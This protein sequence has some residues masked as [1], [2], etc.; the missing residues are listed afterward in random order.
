MKKIIVPFDFSITSENALKAAALLSKKY[1]AELYVLHMLEMSN[2]VLTESGNEQQAKSLFYLKLAEQKLETFLEKDYLKDVDVTPIV[3]HFKVFSELNDVSNEL[4]ADLIVMGSKGSSGMKE[5]FI[6]SNTEKVV[7]YSD[8]PVLIIKNEPQEMDFENVVFAS[9]FFEESIHSYL[10]ACELFKSLDSKVHLLYVNLPF[11][12]FKSSTEI[13]K[14]VSNFLMKAN[15][16]L[17]ALSSVNIVSDY[18]VEE[19]VLN[20]ANLVGADLIT[21]ATH[22]RT[23]ISHFFEGSVAES[24]TNHATLPVMTFRIS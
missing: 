3:K 17:D 21:I 5:V 23:G 8:I 22:G 19:G 6:G 1:N 18:T 12:S 7:R 16:N 15:G 13:Q 20:F 14:R 4:K 10:K 2:A 24:I 11:E 9:D